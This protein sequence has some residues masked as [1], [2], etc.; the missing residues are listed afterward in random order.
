MKAA[1]PFALGTLVLGGCTVVG[2]DTRV[3]TEAPAAFASSSSTVAAPAPARTVEDWW[4]VFGDPELNTL[5]A[6]ALANSPTLV[7]ALAR[8]D[9]ARA[10]LGIIR[11]EASPSVNA[12]G[13]AR[14]AGESAER[15]LPLPGKPLTYREHGDSYRVAADAS[16]EFDLW[17]RVK[18]SVEG[19]EANLRAA[20]S[21]QRGVF[22]T[23]TA[24]IAQ[25]YLTL[26]ALDAEEQVL[27]Q[28]LRQRM[29]SV[30]MLRTRF[31]SGFVT[32]VEV[33]R[34]E[35][36]AAGI[37]SELADLQRRRG[38]LEH[39]L[40]V[41]TGQPPSAMASLARGALPQPPTIPAGLPI[42]T[43][44]RRPDIAL[45][46]ATLS[47]RLAEVGVAQAAK[48]PVIRLT[49]SAGFESLDLTNLVE[50]PSQFWQ[51]GPSVSLPIFTAGRTAKTVA[52]AEARVEQSRA[53]HRQRTLVALREVEDALVDLR[54][55]TEQREHVQR[56][57]TSAAAAA[58]LARVR[59][60][61]GYTTYLEALDAERTLL[62]QTRTLAQL[63]GA[64][65]LSTV[66]LIRALGG[67]WQ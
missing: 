27:D 48:Y 33:H 29:D 18:R 31:E 54:H 20:E 21:D 49:G 9:E 2:P 51:L 14:L 25:T 47:A 22:L 28:S 23:L 10:R 44:R 32:E 55:Q 17:G 36:E 63:D 45:A 15:E 4:L 34:S 8:V 5:E 58:Q 16:Y 24:D 61:Q 57:S 35:A 19:A 3:T 39:A 12:T 46:E 52:I 7:A 60:E 50:R 26:R 37:A 1:L 13:T 56:A 66:R 62:A 40:A 42:E 30:A 64:R 6:Q 38:L 53:E 41:F 11:A 59:Y 43:L 65:A 67:A